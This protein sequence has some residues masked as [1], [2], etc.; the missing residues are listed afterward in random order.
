MNC[1]ICFDSY[2]HTKNKPFV[3]GCGHTFCQVKRLKKFFFICILLNKLRDIFYL[4][5]F[6]S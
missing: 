6:T 4:N 1:E 5:L 2:N 3:L